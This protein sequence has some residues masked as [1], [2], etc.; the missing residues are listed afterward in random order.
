MTGQPPHTHR[1]DRLP[2]E[3]LPFTDTAFRLPS[4]FT[5]AGLKRYSTMVTMLRMSWRH[6]LQ[7]EEDGL[8]N[9]CPMIMAYNAAPG[10]IKRIVKGH[11]WRNIHTAST[12]LNT[13]RAILML[14][15]SWTLDEALCWPKHERT[16]TLTLLRKATKSELLIACR[17]TQTGER[18]VDN[19]ILA[20][21]FCRMG[22][23]I[24]PAW[25]RRRL[26]KE[27]DALALKNVLKNADAT[28]WCEP[29][30]SEI[31][32][33]RFCLL[34]SEA[35]LALE[36]K[37][38]G[39]CAGSYAHRCRNGIEFVFSISGPERATMSFSSERGHLQVK[40][41]FNKPVNLDT[42]SAAKACRAAFI[43]S[44]KRAT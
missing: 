21:D 41:R 44:R 30:Q 2:F 29:W 7:A 14:V 38:Q 18:L 43:Q 1:Q 8:T 16:S 11:A 6:Q 12:A 20:R 5:R 28:P 32:G 10:D 34:N 39:H 13:K 33:Y 19:V 35:A 36:G 27:H 17:H 37:V 22:G 25:G 4:W 40:G 31:Y 9:L 15:G 42:K 24:D 26:R 3:S 23:R